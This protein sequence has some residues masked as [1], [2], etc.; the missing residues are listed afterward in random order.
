M[1]DEKE[2]QTFLQK[3]L[4]YTTAFFILLSTFSLFAFLFLV[5]FVIDPAFTT[6]FMQFD[7][8]PAEC[9]TIDVESRRGTSNCSW[10]SCRE[11]C[12]KELYDC[13]QIRVNYKLPTNVSEDSDGQV[14]GGGAVGGVE[15]DEDSTT[16]GKPRYERSLR[17][18]DYVE[19]DDFPEDDETGLPKP[20]PTGLMGNDSEWYFT[21]AKLF[22]NVKGCGYPPMLNCSIFYRQ[23][24]IIGQNFSCY[25]SKVDP[26]IVISDLDMWQ[27]YM[28]LVYAMA[29]PIPSFIISVI[30]LTIA[31]FKIY[32]EEDVVLVGGEEGEDGGE[33]EGSNATPLPLT[34]SALTP[35]SEAFR[36]DLTSFGYQLQIA[37]ADDV[38]RDKLDEIPNS[39]STQG[40]LSKPMTTS[41][42]TPPGPTAAV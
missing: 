41:I 26:G 42:S 7:T 24:S 9:V 13:T 34:S 32:N 40:N 16:M 17:E 5:P 4:F 29:I 37:M 15:D 36:E 8:R 10:T 2:K 6:I 19:E 33:G 3:L 35:G 21:G 20:F 11:G 23:Y 1:A 25:Y 31:Y 28:N 39:Y 14:E 30:Y 22:P 12:T 18:Y 38:S 27:V